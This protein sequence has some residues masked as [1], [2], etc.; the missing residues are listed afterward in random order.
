MKFGSMLFLCVSIA[1]YVIVL[2]I[3]IDSF[4]LYATLFLNDNHQLLVEIHHLI[5]LVFLVY[6]DL[7]NRRAGR[8]I[9][10]TEINKGGIFIYDYLFSISAFAGTGLQ[11]TID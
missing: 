1:T 2:S 5:A 4:Q 8:S 11:L 3:T 9:F 6:D 10:S 7:Y